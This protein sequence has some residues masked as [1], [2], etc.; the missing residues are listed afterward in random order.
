MYETLSRPALAAARGL[1]FAARM[2][3]GH[4]LRRLQEPA[5]EPRP[6]IAD[7]HDQNS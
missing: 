5:E 7:E 4:G 6:A 3:R 2:L 1:A